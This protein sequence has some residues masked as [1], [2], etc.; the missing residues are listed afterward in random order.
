MNIQELLKNENVRTA[1]WVIGV[2]LLVNLVLILV[3]LIA[4]RNRDG[5]W[6][7]HKAVRTFIVKVIAELKLVEWLSAKNTV[8][9]AVL[10]II[11]SIL[12]GGFI[13]LLDF[14]FFKLRDLLI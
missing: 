2:I 12:L 4:R 5:V 3:N 8:R 11:A 13:A 7:M 10:V 14:G 1:L 9:Y 6:G